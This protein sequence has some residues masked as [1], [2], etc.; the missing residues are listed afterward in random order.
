MVKTRRYL[1]NKLQYE[2]TTQRDRINIIKTLFQIITNKTKL[3]HAVDLIRAHGYC[4][5]IGISNNLPFIKLLFRFLLPGPTG[6]QQIEISKKMVETI[7]AT[8]YVNYQLFKEN[9]LAT[10]L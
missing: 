4:I 8:I 1:E 3:K 5:R 7:A 10:A 6:K 9:R 2:Y